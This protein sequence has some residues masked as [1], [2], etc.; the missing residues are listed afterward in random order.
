MKLD[1]DQLMS[2]IREAAT[3]RHPNLA[4]YNSDGRVSLFEVKQTPH[5]P[6]LNLS[7]EFAARDDDTYHVSDFT[8][9]HDRDFVRNAY[10]AILKREPDE[11]GFLHNLTL[12]RSGVYN[13][14]DILSSLRYSDEGKLNNVTISGLRFPATI[15]TLERIPIAGYLLQMLIALARLPALIRHE[16]EFQ[17]YLVAQQLAIADHVNDTQRAVTS[18]LQRHSASL[19]TIPEQLHALEETVLGR[20][21]AEQEKLQR[22][23]A[24]LLLLSD[25]LSNVSQTLE[26]QQA[27]VKGLTTDVKTVARNLATDE[28]RTID[29]LR[30]WDQLY[31]SFEEQ[32]RGTTE[33]VEERLRFYLP[34]LADLKPESSILDIGSGRGDWLQLLR[35]QGFNPRGI[36]VNEALAERSRAEG[37]DVAGTEMMVYLGQQP[38][39]SLDLVTVFHLIEHFNVSK[40]IRLLDEIKRTLKPGGLLLLETPSPENLVVAACNFYADPTHYKPI[41]PQTLIFLLNH[42][43]F[44][45]LN[46]HYLH[47]VEN[48]PF[49]GDGE[50][51][52]QLNLWFF[53]PRDFAVIARKA[54]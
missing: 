2:T 29:E 9:Y 31:A 48:S 10:R 51:A 15:R 41:Y 7:A 3:R 53:G 22:A 34:F 17:A 23:E 45:D 1:V 19:V 11:A 33:E 40:L 28:N 4:A 16:R 39:N 24:E 44:S 21:L 46:L 52:Q 18:E 27:V 5:R 36:E 26:A 8:K 42:K 37:L 43:G 35:K 13:K 54:Q 6:R 38:D 47:P 20:L 25:R 12:L 30:D 32:F 14:I 50:G 49:T